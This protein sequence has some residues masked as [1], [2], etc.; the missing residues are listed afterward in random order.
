MRDRTPYPSIS[1][2]PFEAPRYLLTEKGL[3][4]CSAART[5]KAAKRLHRMAE[6][7]GRDGCARRFDAR[8]LC[9]EMAVPGV[10]RWLK[11]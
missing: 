5:E 3:R 4:A 1:P 9:G 6:M 11:R 10:S 2:A 8:W 7:A